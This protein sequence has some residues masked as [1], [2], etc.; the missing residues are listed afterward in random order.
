MMETL[1]STMGEADA[2]KALNYM[3]EQ[4]KPFKRKMLVA[5]IP[6][7]GLFLLTQVIFFS[8]RLT[9]TIS[10]EAFAVV[11]AICDIGFLFGLQFKN[12]TMLANFTAETLRDH[13]I[14]SSDG[15]YIGPP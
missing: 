7:F 15:K 4:A 6:W 9:K 11:S 3:E 8:L 13:P 2:I 12:K 1:V 10:P 14:I 5:C